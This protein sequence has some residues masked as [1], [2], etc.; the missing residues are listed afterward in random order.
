M[1][2][3]ICCEGETLEQQVQ[4]EF[5]NEQQIYSYSQKHGALRAQILIH[6]H[7]LCVSEDVGDQLSL[8]EASAS[9]SNKH[10]HSATQQNEVLV[11]TPTTVASDDFL[12]KNGKDFEADAAENS[13]ENYDDD[14]DDE[15]CHD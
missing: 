13:H 14:D 2:S 11:G 8:D 1:G 6:S 3:A 10:N 12:D 15:Q 7:S 4:C 5:I 9:H